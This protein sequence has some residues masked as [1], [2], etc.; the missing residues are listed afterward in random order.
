[1]R[2]CPTCGKAVAESA[3]TVSVPSPF[4]SQRCRDV[5]LNRWFSEKHS[6]PVKTDRVLREAAEA[7]GDADSSENDY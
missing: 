4:C 3:E 6:V 7:S 5:D 2:R 1:M